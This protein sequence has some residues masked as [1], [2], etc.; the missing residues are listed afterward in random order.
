MSTFVPI[1]GPVLAD[2]V[3]CDNKLTARDVAISLPEVVP[4][5]VDLPAMG[6][7]SMPVWQRLEHMEAGIT[8]IGIDNGFR[9]RHRCQRQHQEC[10]LQG[11]PARYPQ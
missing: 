9:N 7:F 11:I 6:T 2:T 4:M 10:G 3:Y 5:T 8:K 1:S